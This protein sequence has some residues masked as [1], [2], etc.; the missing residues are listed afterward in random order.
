MK[1]I[2]YLIIALTFIAGSA[3]AQSDPNAKKVL[4]AVSAK[5]KTFKG[6]TAN[7]TVVSRGAS[8]KVNHSA[9]GKI[10]IKGNK[11]YIK[12]GATEIFSDGNKTWNYNGNNE[13]TVT[14]VDEAD[15]ALT[16]QT[17]LT[18]FYDNDFT[19]KLVSSAGTYNQI[20][21]IPI[22]KRKN[23]KQLNVSVDKSKTMITKAR[24]QDRNNNTIDF[25]LSNINTAANIP[26]NTFVFNKNKYKKNIEVIE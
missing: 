5:L 18:N 20:Q 7:F 3:S 8:G 10:Y 12:Q 21:L 4:D 1:K 11:Y 19:Y 16:P 15:N 26:D 24:V 25:N 22:D 13:V 2:Y 17:L 6:V 14:P 9:A 23:Y